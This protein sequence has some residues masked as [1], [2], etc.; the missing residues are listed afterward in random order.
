[1]PLN[2]FKGSYNQGSFPLL[3]DDNLKCKSVNVVYLITCKVCS[4]QYVG[5]TSR[6]FG[7]R[8]REH[9]DKIRH[10][11]KS[12]LI[13]AH[14]QSDNLHRSRNI[15][16]CLRFQIIE[17][18][19]T[20]DLGIQDPGIIRKRRLDRE[21][22]WI[23]KLRTAHPLGLN[24]RIQA[25]GLSGNATDRNF[26]DFNFYRI[27]NILDTRK[28]RH[29][30]RRNRKTKGKYSETDYERFR[31]ELEETYV[32]NRDRLEVLIL[33]KQRSF[34]DKFIS[35]SLDLDLPAKVRYILTTR[36]AYTK[37]IA[38]RKKDTDKITWKIDF[39]HKILEDV[40]IQAIYNLSEV[41]QFLP[42]QIQG[43]N[44]FRKVFSY[45]RNIGSKILNYNQC[46]KEA[47][48]YSLG[49]INNM[50]CDCAQSDLSDIHH[51]HVMTGNLDIVKD[52]N[53]RKL[54]SNGTRFREVPR[55]NIRTIKGKF[56]DNV[57]D[58]IA[59]I[60][61]KYKIPRDRLKN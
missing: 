48:T 33:S 61:R 4:M 45:G 42:T 31:Q 3:T 46:L 27:V 9:W 51:N 35:K 15:E 18:V 52:D 26:K 44:I 8:M 24:D 49:D 29:R 20:D 11:D 55:L 7:V 41:R 23:A 13:Y 54:V 58:L 14:F 12:Q 6:E 22:Y 10:D 56:E 57:N 21:L 50:S 2:N 40:N 28:R 37:K 53:L 32:S 36:A 43:K 60:V 17:K 30:G 38:P 34:L 25:L 1:M 59:K 5:E 16:D 19:K 47:Q 39:S